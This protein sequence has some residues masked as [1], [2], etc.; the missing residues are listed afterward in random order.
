MDRKDQEQVGVFRHYLLTDQVFR[1]YLLTDQKVEEQI[2]QRA[3]GLYEA[4]GRKDGHSL[5]DWL[6][7]ETE[8]L[9][10]EQEAAA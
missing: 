9:G 6:Q 4:R 10:M 3:Y 2:R 7:A 1:H 8:I 5:D